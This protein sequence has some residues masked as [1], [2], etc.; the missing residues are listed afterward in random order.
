VVQEE[1]SA[2]L[3]PVRLGFFAAIGIRQGQ[4]FVP[5][6]RWKKILS[7]AAAVDDATARALTY[8]MRDQE[9]FYYPN[10]A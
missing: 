4:P 7:E 9:A 3:D 5:D 2:S 10:S 1:P 8:R 6:A